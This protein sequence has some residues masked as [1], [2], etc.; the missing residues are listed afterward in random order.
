[1]LNCLNRFRCGVG[2][3][4]LVFAPD[5]RHG[6]EAAALAKELSLTLQ[7][8]QV[9]TGLYQC[10]FSNLVEFSSYFLSIPPPLPSNLCKSLNFYLKISIP[11][12]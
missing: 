11:Y 6:A 9:A 7:T 10:I 3:L 12:C 1:M 8:I 5:L 2:L 4:E